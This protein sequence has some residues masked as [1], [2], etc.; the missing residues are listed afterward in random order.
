MVVLVVIVSDQTLDRTHRS[1]VRSVFLSRARAIGRSVSTVSDDWMRP[2]AEK[3]LWNLS[4]SD[5]T[6]EKSSLVIGESRVRSV[7]LKHVVTGL[8]LGTS[9]RWTLARPV[10]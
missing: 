10:L 6:L 1:R 9:G 2:V 3:R 8:G 4:G 5:R 7:V